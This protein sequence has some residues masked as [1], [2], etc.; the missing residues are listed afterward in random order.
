MKA[1]TVARTIV[2]VLALINQGLAIWGKDRIEIAENDIYQAVT[3]AFTIAASVA[4][5]WNNNSFTANAVKA[6]EYVK[7]L[8]SR[9]TGGIN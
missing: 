6:D 5:W 9:Q 2:L 4:S 3:L 8:N 1:E 7:E